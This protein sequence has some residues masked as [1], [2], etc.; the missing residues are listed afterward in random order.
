VAGGLGAVTALVGRAQETLSTWHFLGL[1]ETPLGLAALR[2][3]PLINMSRLPDRRSPRALYNFR[4]TPWRAV[5]KII[6]AKLNS[7]NGGRGKRL[8]TVCAELGSPN[9]YMTI[10][11][12]VPNAGTEQ[13][14]QE[15]GIARAQDFARQF[16]EISP[17]SFPPDMGLNGR[18][19]ARPG[20]RL[21]VG[22]RS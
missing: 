11:V 4:C 12:A 10:T 20:A 14:I 18:Q 21:G 15:W 9:E 16:C 6:H 2:G 13:D 8:V 19:I 3:F 1:R 7:T 17:Q 22:T 5:M